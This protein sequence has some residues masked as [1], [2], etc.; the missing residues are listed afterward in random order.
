[1]LKRMGPST[2]PCGTPQVMGRGSVIEVS[3]CRVGSI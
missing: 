2:E 3:R 1:M